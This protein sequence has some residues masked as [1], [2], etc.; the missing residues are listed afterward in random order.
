M[1]N[2]RFPRR[3]PKLPNNTA[4]HWLAVDSKLIAQAVLQT[5]ETLDGS[6]AW[7]VCET[8][9][10][11]PC[12]AQLPEYC[13]CLTDNDDFVLELLRRNIRTYGPP[14]GD[15]LIV[16]LLNP[17]VNADATFRHLSPAAARRR[18]HRW[19]SGA[20]LDIPLATIVRDVLLPLETL[21]YLEQGDSKYLQ[22]YSNQTTAVKHEIIANELKEIIRPKLRRY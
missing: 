20:M 12:A 3:W 16:W 9:L 19:E 7:N 1:P 11:F 14:R 21:G 13:L 2:G 5:I 8:S 15:I 22:E 10:G 4:R 17:A 18:L 6:T